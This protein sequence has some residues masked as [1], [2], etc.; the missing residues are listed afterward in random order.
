[1]KQ[2]ELNELWGTVE[3]Y[4]KSVRKKIPFGLLLSHGYSFDDRKEWK[5][6]RGKFKQDG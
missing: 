1:M 6:L 2:E 3:E 5:K 4:V